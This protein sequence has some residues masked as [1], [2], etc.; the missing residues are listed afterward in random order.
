MEAHVV[1]GIGL[2]TGGTTHGA[3]DTARSSTGLEG[4]TA[5]ALTNAAAAT[6]EHRVLAA[7]PT[8]LDVGVFDDTH[9]WLK[10]RAELGTSG[11]VAASLTAGAAAQERLRD[12]LP[13]MASYLA[14]EAV[15]VS[16]LAVHRAAEGAEM[17]PWGAADGQGSMAGDAASGGERRGAGGQ[18][19]SVG[20]AFSG[21]GDTGSDGDGAMIGSRIENGDAE[22]SIGALSQTLTGIGM[23]IAYQDV[24]VGGWLNVHA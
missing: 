9:G 16:T 24:S 19:P 8:R 3:G 18:E 23:P 1:A 22:G 12:E 11:A 17:R 15:S 2:S 6:V 10:V 13:E 20:M 7:G 5:A 21:G 14:S 4:A